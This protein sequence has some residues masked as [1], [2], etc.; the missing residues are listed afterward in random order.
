MLATRRREEEVSFPALPT[1]VFHVAVLPPP[2]SSPSWVRVLLNAVAAQDYR[3]RQGLAPSV[4]E[5]AFQRT[6]TQTD[7]RA[8]RTFRYV[9]EDPI[10]LRAYPGAAR[11]VRVLVEGV[12]GH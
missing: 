10:P 4:A 5:V 11:C 12:G 2:L 8:E 1:C 3:L 6:V 9:D 7:Q